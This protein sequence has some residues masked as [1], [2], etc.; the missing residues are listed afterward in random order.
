MCVNVCARV[1]LHEYLYVFFFT[2]PVISDHLVSCASFNLCFT[3]LLSVP[4][5]PNV[6]SHI[7][8]SMYHTY[9][10]AI[11]CILLLYYILYMYTYIVYIPHVYS[12]LVEAHDCYGVDR[13]K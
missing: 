13:G 7:L 12:N 11:L 4:F 5:I 8:Y 6:L 3:P 9:V 1:C 10:L 2:N